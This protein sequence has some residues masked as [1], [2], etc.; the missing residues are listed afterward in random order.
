ML[1]AAHALAVTATPG[2]AAFTPRLGDKPRM[3]KEGDVPVS[4]NGSPLAVPST[5][6]ARG[7]RPRGGESGAAASVAL[8]LANG[9]EMNLEDEETLKKLE[10]DEEAKA[11][12]VRRVAAAAS[13]PDTCVMPP[14]DQSRAHPP[15]VP[16][17]ALHCALPLCGR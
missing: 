8:T 10:G 13:C 6:K 2:G 7:K 12:M 14:C 9:E 11:L 5:L 3:L 4:V 15:I 16:V 17:S 1:V